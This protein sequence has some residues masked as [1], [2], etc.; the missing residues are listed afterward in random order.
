[1]PVRRRRHHDDAGAADRAGHLLARS[2]ASRVAAL[3]GHEGDKQ[4]AELGLPPPAEAAG[5]RAHRRARRWP[6]E[7]CSR[8]RGLTVTYGGLNANDD[9]DIT[10]EPGKL[11]G[12]IGP[13]GAGKTTFIDAITGFTKPSAGID[14]LR[15]RRRSTSSHPTTGPTWACRG[16]SSRSS[17]SRT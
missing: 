16:R 4:A 2:P 15:R 9:V 3:P 17:C 10:V 8:R 1:M 12:L 14:R 7:R 5:R 11:T 6:D 13:N